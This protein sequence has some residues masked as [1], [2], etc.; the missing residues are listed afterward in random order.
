MAVAWT[1]WKALYEIKE[2]VWVKIKARSILQVDDDPSRFKFDIAVINNDEDLIKIR[3]NWVYL[4][5]SDLMN[6]E[7]LKTRLASE[8]AY[9]GVGKYN[10]FEHNPAMK[11]GDKLPMGTTP[12]HIVDISVSSSQDRAIARS[13]VFISTEKPLGDEWIAVAATGQQTSFTLKSGTVTL[14]VAEEALKSNLDTWIGGYI[15]VN[16]EDNAEIENLEIL[17]AKYVDPNLYF[18]VNEEAAELINGGASTGRS[19][20]I[21]PLRL[22]PN[23]TVL[24][25]NGLGLSVLYPPYIPACS[26]EMGCSSKSGA[27]KRTWSALI[28]KLKSSSSGMIE[29]TGEIDPNM[30]STMKPEDIEKL[31]S[32]KIEAIVERDAA[33]KE[34][35]TLKSSLES[36]DTLITEGTEVLASKDAEIA[37]QAEKLKSFEDAEAGQEWFTRK[38]MLKFLNLNSNLIQ[39]HL[40]LRWQIYVLRTLRVNL[41]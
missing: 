19:F 30:E 1:Q 10:I 41:D 21:Q 28:E 6:P 3:E 11:V 7:A 20:E 14:T 29:E 34:V 38:K 33:L 36:K 40:P 9:E 13:D 37:A 31:T 8:M 16:H 5:P 18:R 35:E 15:N 17:E 12:I 25:Y 24:E 22:G 32:A 39:Q 23:N 27:I 2:D 26:E 4:E